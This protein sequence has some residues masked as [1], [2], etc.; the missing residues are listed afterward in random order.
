[1]RIGFGVEATTPGC[2]PFRQMQIFSCEIA[3]AEWEVEDLPRLLSE[4]A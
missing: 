3:M 2:Q 4:S 1:M